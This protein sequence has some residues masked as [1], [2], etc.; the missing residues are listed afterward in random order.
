[1][2]KHDLD[3]TIRQSNRD[4][5]QAEYSAEFMEN[6]AKF[7]SDPEKVRWMQQRLSDYGSIASWSY[8]GAKNGRVI[9]S[10]SGLWL[11][12]LPILTQNV[13]HT[14]VEKLRDAK[15]E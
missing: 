2:G 5:K 13:C 3:E 1:M 12:R 15:A 4:E 14:G 9:R 8:N 7:L 6:R 11:N 10:S